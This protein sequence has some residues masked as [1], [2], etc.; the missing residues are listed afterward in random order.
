MIDKLSN[1]EQNFSQSFLGSFQI[2]FINGM[3]KKSQE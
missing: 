2:L 1:K 3:V